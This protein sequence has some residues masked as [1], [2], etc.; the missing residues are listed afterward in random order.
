MLLSV[1]ARPPVGCNRDHKAL[2]KRSLPLSRFFVGRTKKTRETTIARIAGRSTLVCVRALAHAWLVF[3]M[4]LSAATRPP[5]G[6]N[7]E[8]MARV[9]DV[10][11]RC[12]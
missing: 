7:R 1:A 10:T 5:V 9:C 3:A 12:C 8:H 2:A 11:V 4:F 6:S